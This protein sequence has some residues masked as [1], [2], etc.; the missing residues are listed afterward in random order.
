VGPTTT[1]TTTTVPCQCGVYTIQNLSSSGVSLTYTACENGNRILVTLT[2]GGKQT[3]QVCACS[4]I[5]GNATASLLITGPSGSCTTTPTT[6]T[7]TSTTTT[8]STTTTTTSTTTTTTT[9]APVCNCYK[10]ENPTPGY[11]SYQWGDCN[12]FRSE[13]SIVAPDTT[14]YRCSLNTYLNVD[15]A[16]IVTL[17][18]LCGEVNCNPPFEATIGTSEGEVCGGGGTPITVSANSSSF[19]DATEFYLDPLT[20]PDG[21]YY[22]YNGSVYVQ[23]ENILGVATV[24]TPC[25]ACTTTTSTSTT[26]TTTLIPFPT[27]FYSNVVEIEV[28]G[29]VCTQVG[30]TLVMY[31][32]VSIAIGRYVCANDGVSDKIY[33]KISNNIGPGYTLTYNGIQNTDCTLIVC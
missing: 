6:T 3:L 8:S 30:P 24:V 7:T 15:P 14:A 28:V 2:V 9:I 21:L 29:S 10:I 32:T 26:T 4:N 12:K 13:N 27:D 20:Y 19:C 5:L 23:V 25:A 16:L 18:G 33:E 31:S 22:I 1:T 11:L 17:L